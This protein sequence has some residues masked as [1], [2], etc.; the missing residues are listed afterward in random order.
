MA[1]SNLKILNLNCL[2]Q[3]SNSTID[4]KYSYTYFSH[5]FLYFQFLFKFCISLNVISKYFD[6]RQKFLIRRLFF[7]P[8]NFYIF[9][10]KNKF[11][12]QQRFLHFLTDVNL[13]IIN[14]R[15]VFIHNIYNFF[16]KNKKFNFIHKKKFFIY[17]ICLFFNNFFLT[18]NINKIFF[19][20]ILIKKLFIFK[21]FL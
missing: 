13:F 16:L 14:N 17:M 4:S 19:K 9:Y 12:Q 1:K 15:F 5:F 20:K 3:F 21:K 11:M 18:N 2:T 10:R 8:L 6:F 7:R